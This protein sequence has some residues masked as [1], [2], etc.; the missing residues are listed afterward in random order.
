ML[1]PF[2]P[3]LLLGGELFQVLFLGDLAIPCSPA[4]KC[5]HKRK[6]PL[7]LASFSL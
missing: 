2:D 3:F 5:R 6:G 1:S 7:G 4:A